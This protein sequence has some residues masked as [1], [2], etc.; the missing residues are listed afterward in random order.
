M[1]YLLSH[2]QVVFFGF[3]LSSPV[4]GVIADKYGRK[5][6][7]LYYDII[8]RHCWWWSCWI[9]VWFSQCLLTRV[10]LV[11]VIQSTSR[12]WDWWRIFRLECMLCAVV[13]VTF[14]PAYCV[15]FLPAQSRA[16]IICLIQ[17]R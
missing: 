16:V 4:W 15:E 12:V 2:F 6:V 10:L 17:V 7:L 13:S 1:S 14:R 9:C 5:T 11:A 8:Y 3:L